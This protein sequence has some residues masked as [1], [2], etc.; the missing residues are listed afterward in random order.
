MSTSPSSLSS[1]DTAIFEN[2][3]RIPTRKSAARTRSSASK[4]AGTKIRS[5]ATTSSRAREGSSTSKASHDIARSADANAPNSTG[6][7]RTSEATDSTNKTTNDTS[8]ISDPQSKPARQSVNMM[9]PQSSGNAVSDTES[10]TYDEIQHKVECNQQRK[11]KIQRGRQKLSE[12]QRKYEDNTMFRGLNYHEVRKWALTRNPPA[13]DADLQ[14]AQTLPLDELVDIDVTEEVAEQVM[15]EESFV[16]EKCEFEDH[17]W[18]IERKNAV[19]EKLMGVASVEKA[20]NMKFAGELSL[21]RSLAEKILK[22][23]FEENQDDRTRALNELLAGLTGSKIEES[24]AERHTIADTV[25]QRKESR[26]KRGS[27]VSTL[28]EKDSFLGLNKYRD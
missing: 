5:L 8:S 9:T 21:F 1:L 7:H 11:Y 13:M 28:V 20:K 14:H 10:L 12:F 27:E 6:T 17:Q 26:V 24:Q 18:Q 15:T 2:E 19:I 22:P 25:G 3:N 4:T 23:A 16:T